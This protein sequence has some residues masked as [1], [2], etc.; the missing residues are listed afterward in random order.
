MLIW[1][2]KSFRELYPEKISAI[3][4]SLDKPYRADLIPHMILDLTDIRT[5]SFNAA[6]SIVNENFDT[7]FKRIYNGQ[8]YTKN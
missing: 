1:T 2:S 4:N 5:E 7:S 3:K 6:K 8:I